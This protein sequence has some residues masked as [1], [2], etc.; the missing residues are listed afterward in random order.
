MKV[1]GEEREGR[2]GDLA[3]ALLLF[4]LGSDQLS[5]NDAWTS[6]RVRHLARQRKGNSRNNNNITIVI[7]K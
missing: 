6:T 4:R 5:A 2:V 3:P 1:G 7:R